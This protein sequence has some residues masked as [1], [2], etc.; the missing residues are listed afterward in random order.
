M[1][2]ELARRLVEEDLLGDPKDVFY[3]TWEEAIALAQ[4]GVGPEEAAEAIRRRRAEETRNR[5]VTLPDTFVGRPKPLTAGE[6]AQPQDRILRGIPVAPGRVTGPAR[7]I[8]DPRD[9]A[10]IHPGE[11]L[12][13]PV[14]DAAWT[15]LFVTAAG[16]VVDIGGT[17]SHGS[18]VAREYG[19]PAVVNVR[20]GTRVIKTGQRITVDGSQGLVIL[21][22][23]QPDPPG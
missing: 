2:R 15:P 22:D 10:S 5:A 9:N 11:I 14:T 7:V 21:E 20:V 17:L 8:L 1:T 19:R 6:P 12:V 16:I 23:K 3:L 4:G 13:A 18:I